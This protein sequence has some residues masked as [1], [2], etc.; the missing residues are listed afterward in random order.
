MIKVFSQQEISQSPRPKSEPTNTTKNRYINPMV[1]S[2]GRYEILRQKL[3]DIRRKDFVD[4]IDKVNNWQY[5]YDE[6]P[7]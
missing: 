7:G 1:E 2:M 4:F 5:V 3:R 6:L